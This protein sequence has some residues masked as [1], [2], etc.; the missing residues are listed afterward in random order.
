MVQEI[1]ETDLEYVRDIKTIANAVGY[2]M[3]KDRKELSTNED[4]VTQL[5]ADEEEIQ[6]ALTIATRV[7]KEM[8]I[9]GWT[10]VSPHGNLCSNSGC[11]CRNF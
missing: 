10:K 11:A 3:L 9:L 7:V 6:L 2:E 5:W 4:G 8:I 1:S